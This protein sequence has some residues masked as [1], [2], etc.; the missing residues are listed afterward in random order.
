M[1]TVFILASKL[2]GT[3]EDLVLLQ[4]L[5]SIT[6]T[7]GMEEEGHRE[8]G[9]PALSCAPLSHRIMIVVQNNKVFLTLYLEHFA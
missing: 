3:E 9:I 6:K 8:R 1:Y 5:D 7:S 2:N 4:C